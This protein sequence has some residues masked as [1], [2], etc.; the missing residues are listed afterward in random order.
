MPQS[1]KSTIVLSIMTLEFEFWIAFGLIHEHFCYERVVIIFVVFAV[2]IDYLIGDDVYSI[3]FVI[4]A[5]NF[6]RFVNKVCFLPVRI[7]LSFIVVQAVRVFGP[8][9][10]AY[11]NT[12]Y[13]IKYCGPLGTVFARLIL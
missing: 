7:F 8:S 13:I 9:G 6:T 11:L 12:E 10:D 2:N 3:W 5:V 1:L 4:I